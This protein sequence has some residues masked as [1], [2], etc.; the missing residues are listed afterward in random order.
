M[1]GV[2]QPDHIPV[3]RYQLIIAGL[4][5]QLRPTEIS[6]MEDEMAT[7]DLPDRTR[8]TSGER[9]ALE[10]TMMIPAHH[11]AEVLACEAWYREGMSPVSPSYKK[12]GMIIMQSLTGANAR[13]R[14]LIGA[15]IS[16]RTDPD[17]EMASDGEMASLE[18]TVSVD[19][20]LP[21]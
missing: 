7:T 3:N 18:Y 16:K 8:A 5:V 9:N 14:T 21:G 13:V 1:K 12:S 4:P 20:C 2:I 17:L 11:T 15:F 10:F 6:G 19:D